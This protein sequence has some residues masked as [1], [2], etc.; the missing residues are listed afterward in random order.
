MIR[1]DAAAFVGALVGKST[2]DAALPR[3]FGAMQQIVAMPR[4]YR[5]R[6]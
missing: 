5:P 1:G 4:R 3:S 2:R 6:S